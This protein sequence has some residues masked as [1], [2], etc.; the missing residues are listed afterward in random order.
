MCGTGIV[1][2]RDVV[3]F[4]DDPLLSNTTQLPLCSDVDICDGGGCTDDDDD[5][6]TLKPAVEP[7]AGPL[8]PP[9]VLIWLLICE[10]FNDVDIR[11]AVE[12]VVEDVVAA[13]G[14]M[15]MG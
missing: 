15:W 12:S 14:S 4:H 6:K 3:L 13:V 5:G 9:F 11:L 10:L 1:G 8:G 7:H 2:D